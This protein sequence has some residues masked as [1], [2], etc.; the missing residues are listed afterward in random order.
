MFNQIE[1]Y[2]KNNDS[3]YYEGVSADTF[4]E[5]TKSNIQ[6]ITRAFESELVISNWL[7][8]QKEIE[9]LFE[10]CRRNEEG[11]VAT[12]IPQLGQVDPS[13]WAL[14]I[15]TV[16]GQRFS[17][18]NFKEYF[19]IQSVSKP[20]TYAMALDNLGENVVH[21]YVGKEPSGRMFNELILNHEKKPHNPM[22]NPGAIV[23]CSL[24]HSMVDNFGGKP[25]LVFDRTKTVFDKLAGGLHVGFNTSVYI[26]E[27]EAADRNY[28]IAFYLKEHKCFP[29]K[30]RLGDTLKFYF[31]CCSLDVTTRI[32]ALMGATLANSGVNPITSDR[33]FKANSVKDTLSL[34]YS[35]G[36]YDYSGEFAF[37]VGLPGKSGVS[38]AM[39]IAIP[40]V[41]GIGLWSP[42]LGRLGN[43]KRGIQ[44]C[45]ELVKKYPFHQYDNQRVYPDHADRRKVISQT[46]KTIMTTFE[47]LSAAAG[48]H[49][50]ILKKFF[51]YGINLEMTDYDGRT[52]L[53]LAAVEGH[54]A[55][56]EF[57]VKNAKVKTDPV[58]RWGQTPLLAAQNNNQTTVVSFL[59]SYETTE[60]QSETIK[61]DSGNSAK[62]S[63][64]DETEFN[65]L[66]LDKKSENDFN[67]PK[68]GD[69]T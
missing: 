32:L 59:K 67:D 13:N 1:E 34:M 11:E 42:R 57:L 58:D 3:N 27:Q 19:T 48:G 21:E 66:E 5:L 68:K 6:L 24:I 69:N 61:K 2:K 60:E 64:L 15:C 10:L 44:F 33:I 16:D 50:H 63:S 30:S 17:L 26:S 4:R 37:E 38:G 55:C 41:M 28:A 25:S 40:D 45:K 51:L 20:F 7:D 56:V 12:Y 18:G 49:L 39:V 36:M 52:P 43:S 9:D 47:I 62:D 54:L 29:P 46:D 65:P 8:F 22:I 31:R 53:H 35:C 23:V 14:S